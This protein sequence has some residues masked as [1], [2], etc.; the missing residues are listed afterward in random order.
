MG[1]RLRYGALRVRCKRGDGGLVHGWCL[2]SLDGRERIVV[3]ECVARCRIT[4][5][6]F[7]STERM[8][9]DGRS[10]RFNVLSFLD[11]REEGDLLASK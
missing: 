8:G 4:G 11:A 2:E 7:S 6:V 10:C 1:W 3:M 5:E 9:R